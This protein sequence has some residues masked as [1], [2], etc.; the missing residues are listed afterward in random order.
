MKRLTLKIDITRVFKIL[1]LLALVLTIN[2]SLVWAQHED[3]DYMG[4]H[5]MVLLQ[6][7]AG[8]FYAY[9]LPLY[10]KPH[11]Y[12]LL[13][14]VHVPGEVEAMFK[15]GEM[16]TVLPERFDLMRLVNKEQLTLKTEFFSGHFERGGKKV[17]TGQLEYGSLVYGRSLK[18]LEEKPADAK[19]NLV[20]VENK[21][22]LYVHEIE[23]R[24]SY[25][26]LVWVPVAEAER[27]EEQVSCENPAGSPQSN[28]DIKSLVQNCFGFLPTYTEYL[29][30]Q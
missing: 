8:E 11:D 18:V 20:A 6:S 23:K 3:H 5:G 12:Q 30:F 7:P 16:I 14:K 24:P 27:F 26:A 10:S 15:A 1:S 21:F 4:S 28:K 2:F 9:H 17:H 19:F 22:Y 13:Y 25:D 29:D